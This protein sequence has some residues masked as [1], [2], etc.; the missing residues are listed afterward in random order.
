ME[1]AGPETGGACAGCGAALCMRVSEAQTAAARLHSMRNAGGAKVAARR[2]RMRMEDFWVGLHRSPNGG[3][4]WCAF[5]PPS[6]HTHTPSLCR[7]LWRS[8]P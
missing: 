6:T 3:N 1:C 5:I 2:G 8:P 7:R 4:E